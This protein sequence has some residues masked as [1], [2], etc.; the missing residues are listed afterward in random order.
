MATI[1]IACKTI[2]KTD[3]VKR[4]VGPG[5]DYVH[6][7]RPDKLITFLSTTEEQIDVIIWLASVTLWQASNTHRIL[8]V[9]TR[10]GLLGR[11]IARSSH[12]S[13]QAEVT[14]QGLFAVIDDDPGTLRE[15]IGRVLAPRHDQEP[16]ESS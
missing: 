3:E 6:I 2:G 14:D 10:K 8:E 12:E 9:L 1:L 11:T 7:A 4:A 5:H 16:V 13:F 15:A